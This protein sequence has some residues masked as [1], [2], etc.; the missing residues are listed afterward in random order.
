MLNANYETKAYIAPE[1]PSCSLHIFRIFKKSFLSL[2]EKTNYTPNSSKIIPNSINVLLQDFKQCILQEN[3]MKMKKIIPFA[4]LL[5]TAT[6][7]G[8]IPSVQKIVNGKICDTCSVKYIMHSHSGGLEYA[9][10]GGHF[11]ANRLSA[12]LSKFKKE[13]SDEKYEQTCYITPDSIINISF[14][15]KLRSQTATQYLQSPWLEYVDYR[16][17]VVSLTLN[18]KVTKSNVPLSSLKPLSNYIINQIKYSQE[19]REEFIGYKK[20]YSLGNIHLKIGD[21]LGIQLFHKTYNHP[22]YSIN[23]KRVFDRP[24]HFVYYETPIQSIN[25][26]EN[27]QSFLS[28]NVKKENIGFGDSTTHFFLKKGNLGVFNFNSLETAEIIEYKISGD[29]QWKSVK[30][31]GFSPFE[32]KVYVIVDNNDVPPGTT[33][34]VIFRYKDLPG[35]E[36]RV[37]IKGKEE[38]TQNKWFIISCIVLFTSLLFGLLYFFKRKQDR[39]QIRKLHQKNKDIETRLSLLSGQL[40]P[41]FLFNSLHAIQ[42]TINSNNINEAN[43]YI[44]SVANFMR[45]IMDYGKK[46]FISLKE[47]LNL[48]TDYLKLEQKRNHFSFNTH[49]EPGIDTALIDFPP[50]LLQP[51]LE[52]SLRHAFV[53]STAKPI[54]EILI[55]VAQNDLVITIKDNGIGW[56]TTINAEGHGLGLVRKRIE[57]LNEKI[58]DMPISTMVVAAP[59]EGTSTIFTFKNWLA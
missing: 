37:T 56:N 57:L 15:E 54:L 28:A 39:K 2:I 34:E 19:G 31:P 26:K 17:I 6:A 35:S 7:T 13:K 10:V 4:L 46:E 52:N 16:D 27:L 33:K 23:I 32:E 48:E 20:N 55:N 21:I 8:Q 45:T 24:S 51:V 18:N 43:E 40:N 11:N 44:S 53:N 50:L 47:E 36:F 22:V 38:R 59:D 14:V 25:I 58:A 5:L 41:H 9:I 1:H 42:G 30:R 3:Q 12:E 29:K 49:I